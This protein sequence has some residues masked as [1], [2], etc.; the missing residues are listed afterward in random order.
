M[1]RLTS[2]VLPHVV[3]RCCAQ[4]LPKAAPVKLDAV[5]GIRATVLA[6]ECLGKPYSFG[7]KEKKH[8][9]R[10]RTFPTAAM[11]FIV[12]LVAFLPFS[13]VPE[14]LSVSC[15]RNVKEWLVKQ[16][17]FHCIRGQIRR[18]CCP[19]LRGSPACCRGP[20]VNKNTV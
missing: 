18:C 16:T 7:V 10:C 20:P 1:K 12:T 11:S 19:H 9:F 3:F 2:K 17:N 14:S 5:A 4:T 6:L 8:F 13:G 15:K